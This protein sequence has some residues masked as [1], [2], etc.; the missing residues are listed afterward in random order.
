MGQD[1]RRVIQHIV[2]DLYFLCPK[3]LRFSSNCFDVRSKSLWWRRPRPRRK[4]LKTKSH[5]RLGWLNQHFW[6]ACIQSFLNSFNYVFSSHCNFEI[7]HCLVLH[8]TELAWSKIVKLFRFQTLQFIVLFS[9]VSQMFL[10]VDRK[11]HI[12]RHSVSIQN[13]P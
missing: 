4:E 2:P 1:H 12:R 11:Q 5:P 13:H 3:Y 10:G 6:N 8:H 9:F 7:L